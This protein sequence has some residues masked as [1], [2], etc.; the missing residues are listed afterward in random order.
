MEKPITVREA[1]AGS[2]IAAF[3][4]RLLDYRRRDIFTRPGDGPAPARE[5]EY[6]EH[7]LRLHT[8]AADNSRFLFFVRDGLDIGLALA[9]I[10][11]SEDGKCFV[12]DFCVYPERRGGGTGNLCAN[13]LIGWARENGA[14]YFELNYG[15]DERRLRFWRRAGFVENGADEWG[16]PLLLLPPE[17]E[18]P[19]TV[20]ELQESDH[21]Q[22]L[23]LENGFRAETG[24]GC[25][26]ERAQ[27]RLLDAVR[28]GRITFFAAKR[29]S[30]AVGIC[31]VSRSFSTFGCSD[32][33]VFDDFFV[34]PAFRGRGIARK[35][36]R[37]A[38][39]WCSANGLA[40][41]TACCAPC[42]EGMYR[43]LGFDVR[44]GTTYA[45][46]S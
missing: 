19:F 2:D 35:L 22:L 12:C 4:E 40:S 18:V 17:G 1:L 5:E 3:R 13:A 14:A 34:E 24:E 43:A 6:W 27:E 20:E 16:E 8:R 31:S 28:G 42:D 36:A 41:L 39:A 30:R 26:D 32:V 45:Y 11:G 38:Q 29:G 33:G 23:R 25:L 37:S 9:V 44:L 10:Y 7:M 46:L 15:G 21:W